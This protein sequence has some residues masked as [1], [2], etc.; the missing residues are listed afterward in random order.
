MLVSQKLGNGFYIRTQSS[1]IEERVNQ[2]STFNNNTLPSSN[3]TFTFFIQQ[4]LINPPSQLD[5]RPT[6]S[7]IQSKKTEM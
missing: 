3:D 1:Q 2:H 7:V 6:F 4:T 5:N